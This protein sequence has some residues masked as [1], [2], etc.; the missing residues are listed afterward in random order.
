MKL[1]AALII[2]FVNITATASAGP[3][4]A[5][6]IDVRI[7]ELRQTLLTRRTPEPLLVPSL[8]A[9]KRAELSR[10]IMAP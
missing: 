3:D 2:L 5:N 6:N 1:L 10:K 9:Q 4:S 8:N 7:K